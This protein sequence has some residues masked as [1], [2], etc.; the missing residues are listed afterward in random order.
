VRELTIGDSDSQKV[1]Y[2]IAE[3]HT[4]DDWGEP[5]VL[6]RVRLMRPFPRITPSLVAA[7]SPVP[8]VVLVEPNELEPQEKTRL[9]EV[10]AVGALEL[11]GLKKRE[12]L[13]WLAL[14]E[15]KTIA[16]RE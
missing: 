8:H 15:R 14:D 1:Q 7:L 9:L 6:T 2:L 11:V 3:G 5:R 4:L 12:H 10:L 13:A 16:R